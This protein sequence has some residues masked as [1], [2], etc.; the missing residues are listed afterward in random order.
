MDNVNKL[1]SDFCKKHQLPDHFKSILASNLDSKKKHLLGPH[2]MKRNKDSTVG[3]SSETPEP[4]QSYS[5]IPQSLGI[6][7]K[8]G[9]L[10]HRPRTE[11][12]QH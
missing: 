7:P 6:E 2:K 11:L 5:K 12:S 3:N 9:K 4:P 10:E 1:A 8:P